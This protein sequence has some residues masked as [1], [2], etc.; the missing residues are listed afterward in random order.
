MVMRDLLKNCLK[1]DFVQEILYKFLEL[2][3]TGVK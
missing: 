3:K 1:E 2:E